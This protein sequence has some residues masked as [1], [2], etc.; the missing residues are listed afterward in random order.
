M[1]VKKGAKVWPVA[2]SVLLQ[3]R[4]TQ[5]MWPEPAEILTRDFVSSYP[6]L[7]QPVPGSKKFSKF[8]DTDRTAYQ[9][10]YFP[11]PILTISKKTK[12]KIWIVGFVMGV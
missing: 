2:A 7:Q 3:T 5:R 8:I 9:M 6:N 1:I 11:K 4:N 10:I 12:K